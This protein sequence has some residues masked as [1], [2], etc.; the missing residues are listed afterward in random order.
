ML[1]R[2]LGKLTQPSKPRKIIRVISGKNK[3]LAEGD[4]PVKKLKRPAPVV[5]EAYRYAAKY[6]FL[7]GI[8]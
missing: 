8:D 4:S 2:S 7:S 5:A 6:S 1:F 3:A